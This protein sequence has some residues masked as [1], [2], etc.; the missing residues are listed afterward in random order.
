MKETDFCRNFI[1]AD[2]QSDFQMYKDNFI[3]VH[4]PGYHV[5]SACDIFL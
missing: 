2:S 5:E 1:L 3:Y 4:T